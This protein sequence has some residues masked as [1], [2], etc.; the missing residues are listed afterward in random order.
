[1]SCR[2]GKGGVGEPADRHL[3]WMVGEHETCPIR[4]LFLTLNRPDPTGLSIHLLR[5]IGDTLPFLAFLPTH[6]GER[7]RLSKG[8]RETLTRRK[9]GRNQLKKDDSYK[10]RWSSAHP[11]ILRQNNNDTQLR[12]ARLPVLNA[13]RRHQLSSSH[14]PL[15]SFVV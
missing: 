8:L 15:Y 4:H 12:N 9:E 11:F 5:F 2:E 14:S 3:D 1:M 10:T 6:I 7:A 13:Q